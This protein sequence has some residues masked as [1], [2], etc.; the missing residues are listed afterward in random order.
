MI[1]IIYWSGSGNTE[2]M[3]RYIAQGIEK[4]A[5]EVDVKSVEEANYKEAVDI[6]VLGCPSMGVEELEEIEMAP[7]VESLKGH[8]TGQKVALFGSYGWGDGE[9]MISW[10]EQMK[11]YGAEL[12]SSSLI[13]N[14]F[15]VGEDEEQCIR[16]GQ[17]LI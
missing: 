3:A 14:G 17:E 16:F 5:R 15:T 6:L 7:F 13:I 10:E 4:S 12:V 9:W 11:E 8:I 1:K 2:N